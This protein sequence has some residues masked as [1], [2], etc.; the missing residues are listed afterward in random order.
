MDQKKLNEDLFLAAI[1]GSA[2]D[3]HRLV[4]RGANINT[5]DSEQNTPLIAAAESGNVG[6]VKQLLIMGACADHKNIYGKT[7]AMIAQNTK[8]IRLF[9]VPQKQNHNER[10]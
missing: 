4:K 5:V 3:I 8:L 6:T 1:W 10:Q 2:S 9:S 7:A